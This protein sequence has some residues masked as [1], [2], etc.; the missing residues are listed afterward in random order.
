MYNVCALCVHR[1]SNCTN[2]GNETKKEME[3]KKNYVFVIEQ[4]VFV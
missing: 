2:G 1:K 4:D 3:A